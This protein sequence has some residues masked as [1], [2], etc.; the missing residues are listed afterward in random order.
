MSQRIGDPPTG[1]AN[2][3]LT[4]ASQRVL[5]DEGAIKGRILD[6]LVHTKKGTIPLRVSER[7]FLGEGLKRKVMEVAGAEAILYG[8]ARDLQLAAQ[9]LSSKPIPE[10]EISTS[11]GFQ[12]DGTFLYRGV[13]VTPK[14]MVQPTDKEI[15][16]SGSTCARDLGLRLAKK[17]EVARIA[18]HLVNDFLK[19]KAAKVMFP[20]IGHMVLAAFSSL[21]ILVTGCGKPALHLQGPS[22]S[23]KTFLAKL[24]IAFY[25]VRNDRFASW[26]W[27]ANA[28]EVEGH[29]FRDSLYLVDDYKGS[30]IA[31]QEVIRVIQK[32]ADERGRSRLSPPGNVKANSISGAFSCRRVKTSSRMWSP[33]WAAPL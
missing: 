8:S 6:L 5:K 11:V 15:D 21:I 19:L 16:L 25:G 20:L 4:I 10:R 28:I 26:N 9:E 3:H 32:H 22:G 17:E 27:T 23:G 18:K 12:P 7:E 30:V 29:S 13:L 1:I 14:G 33:F 31:P 2:F 24:L